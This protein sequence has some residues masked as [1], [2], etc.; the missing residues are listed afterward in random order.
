[1]RETSAHRRR[2]RLVVGSLLLAGAIHACGDSEPC[3]HVIS[4]VARFDDCKAIAVQ[5]GCSDE[6]VYSNTNKRCK[7]SHCSDCNAKPTPTAT[8]AS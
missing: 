7:V 4:D 6:I 5:R 1:M 3:N 8:P 2:W